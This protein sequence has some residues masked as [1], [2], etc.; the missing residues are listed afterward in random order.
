VL[1]RK[2]VVA[3]AIPIAL[4]VALLWP[5]RVGR[6]MLDRRRLAAWDKAWAEVEPQWTRRFWSRG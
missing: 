2:A 6:W 4:R 1:A 5:A 3:V